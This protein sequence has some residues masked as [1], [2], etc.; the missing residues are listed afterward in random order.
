[1]SGVRLISAS[2]WPPC[3]ARSGCELYG[4]YE[5]YWTCKTNRPLSAAWLGR[6]RGSGG[7]AGIGGRRGRAPARVVIHLRQEIVREVGDIH[8]N[9]R[10]AIAE[11]GVAENRRHR[12]G[13]AEERHDE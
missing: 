3:M 7:S 1:R 5:T 8:L 10:Q 11:Q 9:A 2:L 4:T 13:D 12:Q 6:L